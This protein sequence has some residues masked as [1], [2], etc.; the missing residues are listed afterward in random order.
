MPK[1]YED[2]TCVLVNNDL[3]GKFFWLLELAVM[4]DD[5]SKATSISFFIDDFDSLSYEFN[6]FTFTL[7]YWLIYIHFI[8]NQNQI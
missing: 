1:I 6:N 2:L 4:F 7:S 5:N 3:C 8:L